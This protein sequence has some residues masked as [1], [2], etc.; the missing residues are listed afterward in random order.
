MVVHFGRW[1][2]SFLFYFI[3]IIGPYITNC[4]TLPDLDQHTNSNLLWFESV[5]INYLGHIKWLVQANTQQRRAVWW[6][7]LCSCCRWPNLL[8]DMPRYTTNIV[9]VLLVLKQTVSCI[10]FLLSVT[11]YKPFLVWQS[12][13]VFARA[14]WCTQ[15]MPGQSLKVIFQYC[16]I[17]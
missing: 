10:R 6:K 3:I 13:C 17:I 14:L 2:T 1:S 9:P 12:S 8:C 4:I 7:E 11:G 5:L 15:K 16:I